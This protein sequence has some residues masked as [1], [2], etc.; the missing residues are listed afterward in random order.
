[1]TK[2]EMKYATYEDF[3][4]ALS[5]SVEKDEIFDADI[6]ENTDEEDRI[7]SR[8]FIQAHR[9][10]M[11]E[12]N[13][14][15]LKDLSALDVRLMGLDNP[16]IMNVITEETEEHCINGRIVRGKKIIDSDESYIIKEDG[17]NNYYRIMK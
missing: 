4:K 8:W 15:I 9:E 11:F 1:M 10:L 16:L 6:D 5:E 14:N 13:Q 3:K 2:K 7:I 12:N 17:K